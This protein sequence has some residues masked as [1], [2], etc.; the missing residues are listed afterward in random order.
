MSL[1]LVQSN[2]NAPLGM[3]NLI[4]DLGSAWI[5]N[6]GNAKVCAA[7]KRF[8]GSRLILP[9][10]KARKASSVASCQVKNGLY[11]I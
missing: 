1:G 3:Y 5:E 9:S 10:I 4:D 2:C 7:V 8:E 11:G 6:H